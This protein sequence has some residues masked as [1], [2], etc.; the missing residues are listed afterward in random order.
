MTNQHRGDQDWNISPYS[1]VDAAADWMPESAADD[2]AQPAGTSWAGFAPSYDEWSAGLALAGL[3]EGGFDEYLAHI[4]QLPVYV[5][6][7]R[8]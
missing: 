8:W 3:P 1:G 4:G 6:L 7:P 5:W 2:D